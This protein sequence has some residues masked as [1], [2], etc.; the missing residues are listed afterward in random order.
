[1]GC[2]KCKADFI[3]WC[4]TC[5]VSATG[6]GCSDWEDTAECDVNLGYFMNQ[7]LLEC[8]DE[9]GLHSKNDKCNFGGCIDIIGVGRCGNAGVNPCIYCG[10]PN[11]QN[12]CKKVGV[13]S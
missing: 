3:A 6:K 12:D 9:C 1:M 5:S 13:G 4:T 10:A 7:E 8:A 2:E 11:A